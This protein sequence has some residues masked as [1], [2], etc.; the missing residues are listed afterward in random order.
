MYLGFETQRKL[1]RRSSGMF[2]INLIVLM[3]EEGFI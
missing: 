2:L 3:E 1:V